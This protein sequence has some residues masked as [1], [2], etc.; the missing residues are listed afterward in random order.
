MIN[1]DEDLHLWWELSYAQYLTVPRSIMQSMPEEWQKKMAKL[2]NELDDTYDWRPQD[3]RYWCVLKDSK[4]KF[5]T[6]P[7]CMYRY[8]DLDY[9]KSLKKEN[10]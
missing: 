2:L 1:N 10:K 3:G 4:G 7:L 5:T 6:D 9:I 8:P